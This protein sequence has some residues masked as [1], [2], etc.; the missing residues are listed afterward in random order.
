M[1][2]TCPFTE[3]KPLVGCRV[4]HA[5]NHTKMRQLPNLQSKRVYDAE[6]GRTVRVRLS[7]RA[8]RTVTKLGL[9]AY[10][11]KLGLSLNDV[12]A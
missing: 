4:S 11:R 12:I 7:T 2:R 1:A 10:L 5:N 8:L 6:L 3:K 9:S